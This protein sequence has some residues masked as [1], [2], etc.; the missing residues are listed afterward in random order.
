MMPASRNR[1][2]VH[3]THA[4]ESPRHDLPRWSH[5]WRAAR[6]NEN[7]LDSEMSFLLRWLRPA[8]LSDRRFPRDEVWL[9]FLPFHLRAMRMIP[10]RLFFPMG[11]R[12]VRYSPA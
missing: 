3:L 6:R 9:P 4:R 2:V 12:F 5:D 10:E 7:H 8:H 1:P 11:R